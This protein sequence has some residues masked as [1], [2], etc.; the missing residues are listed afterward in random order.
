MKKLKLRSGFISAAI[1][2]I[3]MS[4]FLLLLGFVEH[5]Q[6]ERAT[7]G[8]RIKVKD[9]N[10]NYFIEPLDIE[11]LLN[12]KGRKLVG[13][14]MHDINIPMLEKIVYTNAYVDRAEVYSTIDGYVNIDVW[15]RD[16]V[17]RIINAENEHYY[18]DVNGEFMPVT[19]KFSKSVVVANG[20]IFDRLKQKSLTFASPLPDVDVKPILIQINEVAHFLRENEF[21]NSQIEQ[22]YVNQNF[23]LELIPRV[24]NHKIIIGDSQNLSGK[25]D[26]L[27]V[28]Y[29]EGATKAGWNKYTD[30]NL[31]YQGQVVC[32]K[33]K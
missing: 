32:T 30:I 11:N 9:T 12:A 17:V 24:G 15:Q 16:P 6:H 25:L 31:K 18:I 2:I 8:L 1:W 29:T 3:S 4:G 33:A 5:N 19:D 27:H 28:F 21:W 7:V 14:P 10:N 20:Y 22:I 13:M 23:E 26:N